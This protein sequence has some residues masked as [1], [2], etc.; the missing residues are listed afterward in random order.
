[1]LYKSSLIYSLYFL[2]DMLC[3]YLKNCIMIYLI[4]DLYLS[5]HHNLFETVSL[6]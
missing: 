5:I 6:S 3:L 4:V 1:M 2:L